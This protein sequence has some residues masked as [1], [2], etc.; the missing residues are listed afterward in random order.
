VEPITI[1][2][3]SDARTR[4][5]STEDWEDS[6][7][8]TR[9]VGLFSSDIGHVFNRS[10]WTW[11]RISLVGNLLASGADPEKTQVLVVSPQADHISHLVSHL[12]FQTTVATVDELLGGKDASADWKAMM[13]TAWLKPVRPVQWWK[14]RKADQKFDAIVMLQNSALELP[15]EE[16]D[17]VFKALEPLMAPKAM[18][19]SGFRVN[20]TARDTGGAVPLAAWQDLFGK[21][22]P[23]GG[24][25]FTAQGGIDPR[26]PL[27]NVIRY[28]AFN[29][30]ETLPGMSFG[31]G[32]A[33]FTVAVTSA[34][35]PKKLAPAPASAPQLT[36]APFD[37]AAVRV[38]YIDE[39]ASAGGVDGAELAMPTRGRTPDLRL[40]F[41]G[42]RQR[43]G[44]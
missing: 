15:A 22:G 35:W 11:E 3:R 20:L 2:L 14:D 8:M 34:L 33:F 23:L 42:W 38:P 26:T 6:H 13:K 29:E 12:R 19:H 37:P 31:V 25:G 9:A 7:W 44:G 30:D 10:W 43:L 1:G 16:A 18:L 5:A 17:A 27:D 41:S 36:D 40:L 28:A 24:R 4:L 39:A 32:D 21:G